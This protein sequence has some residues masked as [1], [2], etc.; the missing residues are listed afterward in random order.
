M[1]ESVPLPFVLAIG[2]DEIA[3]MAI[4]GSIVI[5]VV[6]IVSSA[7]SRIVRT[8]AFEASRREIAAYVAEGTIKADEAQALLEAGKNKTAC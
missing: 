7:I 3:A 2:G 8:R 6:S 5:A 1:V 4:G